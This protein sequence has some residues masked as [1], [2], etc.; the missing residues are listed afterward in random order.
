[1]R[2][3]PGRV[4]HGPSLLPFNSL[5]VQGPMARNVADLALFF[6]V[7]TGADHR[8]PLS[9]SES[10][11]SFLEAAKS[12]QRPAKIAFSV[13]FGFMPVDTEVAEICRGAAKKIQ[14]FGIIVEECHPKLD[15]VIETFW[16]LRSH[17]FA[18]TMGPLVKQ[19]QDH[20][21]REL[22]DNIEIGY[23]L[24]VDELGNAETAR[25]MIYEKMFNFFDEYDLLLVPSTIVPAFPIEQRFVKKC[26]D[27]IFN[28]YVDWMG[29]TFP[30]TLGGVSSPFNSCRF[31][32]KRFASRTTINWSPKI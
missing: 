2:P 1:M 9:F 20:F 3:S 8:D 18:M 23:R 17:T 26:N 4:A 29:I 15:N 5:G 13:D 31:Y 10:K 30:A 16:T 25:S 24:S 11:I 19:F 21:K 14:E 27:K 32:Q 7:M 22:L 6:D 12:S 28:T